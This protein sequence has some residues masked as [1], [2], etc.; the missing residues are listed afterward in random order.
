MCSELGMLSYSSYA[1]LY[2]QRSFFFLPITVMKVSLECW[3]VS[4]TRAV[5]GPWAANHS[6]RGRRQVSGG[7]PCAN[8]HTR[9]LGAPV[10]HALGWRCLWIYSCGKKEE[11]SGEDGGF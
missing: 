3:K 5:I 9:A 2:C 11:A 1:E 4:R 6:P 10:K 7:E 8:A